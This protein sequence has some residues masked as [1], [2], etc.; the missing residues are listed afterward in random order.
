MHNTPSLN[1]EWVTIK[2]FGFSTKILIKDVAIFMIG[3]IITIIISELLASY[4]VMNIEEAISEMKKKK[5]KEL[6][7]KNRK[8]IKNVPSPKII[9]CDKCYN[10]Y[11]EIEIKK[12]NII[13]HICQ[14]Y[15][16]NCYY[17]QSG[18]KIRKSQSD[19]KF[20]YNYNYNK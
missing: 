3:L 1:Q 13:G 19:S 17:L 2:L 7:L 6:Y 4:M 18:Y 12:C 10:E 16:T 20:N 15:C 11:N 14:Q 9:Q 8:E 5:M